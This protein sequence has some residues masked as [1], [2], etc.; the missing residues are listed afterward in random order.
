MN[1]HYDLSLT[2]AITVYKMLHDDS[3]K[4]ILLSMG[5]KVLDLSF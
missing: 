2:L 4:L 5:V 1:L 3:F